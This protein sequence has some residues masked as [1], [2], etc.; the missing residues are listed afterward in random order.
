MGLDQ[1]ILRGSH[2]VTPKLGKND[3]WEYCE[4]ICYLRKAYWLHNIILD[5]GMEKLDV[6][7]KDELNTK[8][9]PLTREELQDI[10]QKGKEVTSTKSIFMLDEYFDYEVYS[11]NELSCVIQDIKEWNM[12]MHRYLRNSKKTEYY[13]WSWW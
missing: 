2:N 5:I 6:K 11:D 7:D 8:F 9:I 10:V 1:Y 12:I 4:E 3:E 13:Y